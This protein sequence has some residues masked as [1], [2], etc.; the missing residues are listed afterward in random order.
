VSDFAPEIVDAISGYMN[1]NQAESNLVIVQTL[2]ETPEATAAKLVGFDSE[3]AFFMAT[4]IEGELEVRVAWSYE[5]TT[6]DQVREQLFS[7]LDRAVS[8][9]K[10][11]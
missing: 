6:R 4:V 5:V 2:G 9:Y 10:F 8:M 3:A 7:M 11:D 1:A